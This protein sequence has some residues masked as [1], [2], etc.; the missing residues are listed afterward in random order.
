MIK[1]DATK[2]KSPLYAAVC[3]AALHVLVVW[4]HRKFVQKIADT[5]KQTPQEVFINPAVLT[6]VITGIVMH[7]SHNKQS[8]LL[9]EPYDATPDMD[10]RVRWIS[11]YNKSDVS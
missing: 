8:M 3:A 6:G 4:I 2:L 11:R 7:L 10:M 5:S 9:S 1:F